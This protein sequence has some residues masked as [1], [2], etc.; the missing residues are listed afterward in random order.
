VIQVAIIIGLALLLLHL[1][2]KGLIQVELSMPWFLALFILGLLSTNAGFVNWI[3]DSLGILYRPLAVVFVT[4]FIVLGLITMLLIVV[5]RLRARQ[6]LLVRRLAR[7]ELE[8]QEQ[9]IAGVAEETSA[10]P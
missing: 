7:L 9:I 3:G 2:R 1:V 10:G 4:I 5:T 8:P 6:T